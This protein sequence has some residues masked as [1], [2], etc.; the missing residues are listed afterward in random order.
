MLTNWTVVLLI[1]SMFTFLLMM[2]HQMIKQINAQLAVITS[3]TVEDI[4]LLNNVCI[5][6]CTTT[7]I[8]TYVRSY[9]CTN[10]Y[11]TRP[12]KHSYLRMHT[13]HTCIA[14]GLFEEEFFCESAMV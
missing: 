3:L 9:V 10:I 7:Y 8:A 11:V 6:D 4:Q 2:K 5:L 1:V 12:E 13:K 14:S